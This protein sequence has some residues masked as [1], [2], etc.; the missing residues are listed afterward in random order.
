MLLKSEIWVRAYLRSCQSL[1]GMPVVVRHGD[2]DAGAIFIVLRYPDQT[3]T[4]MGPAPAGFDRE[5]LD[6]GF[7][8]HSGD[9]PVSEPA[10]EA[11]IASQVSFDS[12]LWVVEVEATP[13]REALSAWIEAS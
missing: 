4:V 1:G 12:D 7:V 2:D 9:T 6:R 3:A 11:L 8:V 13:G 5:R 10:A